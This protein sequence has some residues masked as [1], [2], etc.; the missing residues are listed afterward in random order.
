MAPPG[1]RTKE[2]G[3]RGERNDL[4][5]VI[6]LAASH[7]LPA[8][9]PERILATSGGLLSHG[10]DVSDIYRGAAGYVD[11]ILKGKKP[12]DRPVQAPVKYAL[13]I[14][15]K[16]AKAAPPRSATQTACHRRRGDRMSSRRQFITLFGGAAAWPL[17][18]RAEQSNRTR[19]L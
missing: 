15:L 17:T 7:R 18:A 13:V 11:R 9:F 19:H 16:T 6:G 3:E 5:G 12:A 10:S 14:N 2:W 8:V 1:G 4:G